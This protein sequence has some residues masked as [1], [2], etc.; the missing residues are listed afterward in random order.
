MLSELL[1]IEKSLL[2]IIDAQDKLFASQSEAERTLDSIIKLSKVAKILNIPII[3]TEQYPKGLGNTNEKVKEALGENAIFFEKTSFDC[4]AEEGFDA[5]L[6]QSGRRQIIVCGM[7]AHICVLQTVNSLL[8]KG[9][10][11]YFVQD[12]ITSRKNWEYEQGIKRMIADGAVPTCVETFL[13][14]LL[15]TAM[16]PNFKEIQALIK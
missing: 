14:E 16:H 4:T 15:K 7:E 10:C 6:R 5:L 12:A 2:L 9:Y 3:A 11:V 8:H 1:D 13:F